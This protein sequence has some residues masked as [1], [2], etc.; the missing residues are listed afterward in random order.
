MFVGTFRFDMQAEEALTTTSFFR[1]SN[2][3]TFLLAYT[4]FA[5]YDRLLEL[6]LK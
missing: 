6:N 5:H 1:V 3:E 4:L 2:K